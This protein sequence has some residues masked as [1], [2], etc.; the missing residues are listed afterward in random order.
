VCVLCGGKVNRKEKIS[1]DKF[2]TEE[3]TKVLRF[4]F[5]YDGWRH[6]IYSI[7]YDGSS[8]GPLTVSV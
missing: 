7:I 2:R 3:S 4:F 5:L 6:D 8:H 1:V